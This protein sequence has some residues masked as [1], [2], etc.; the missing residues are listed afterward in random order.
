MSSGLFGLHGVHGRAESNVLITN[1]LVLLCK[2]V[3]SQWVSLL[4]PPCGDKFTRSRA[5][6]RVRVVG[7]CCAVIGCMVIGIVS[8][9]CTLSPST[10]SKCMLYTISTGRIVPRMFHGLCLTLSC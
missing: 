5:G 10:C 3:D 8:V 7:V 9:Q 1:T 6:Y 2:Q 4:S